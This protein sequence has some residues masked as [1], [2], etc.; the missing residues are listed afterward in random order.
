VVHV[1]ERRRRKRKRRREEVIAHRSKY[2][3][4]GNKYTQNRPQKETSPADSNG[5]V[6]KQTKIEYPVIFM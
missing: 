4:S 2:H 1:V 6:T 3:V 5:T